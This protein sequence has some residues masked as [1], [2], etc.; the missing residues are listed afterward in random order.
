MSIF[1]MSVAVKHPVG[2]VG[3]RGKFFKVVAVVAIDEQGRANT[4]CFTA[5]DMKKI[6]I[7]QH[8]S[9][10]ECYMMVQMQAN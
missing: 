6:D 8:L 9:F 1:L 3:L 4:G 7:S 10:I 2:E 5:T